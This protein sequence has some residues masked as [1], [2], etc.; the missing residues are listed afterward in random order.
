MVT[1]SPV[2]WK[3]SVENGILN[4]A[5]HPSSVCVVTTS[6]YEFQSQFIGMPL[7]NSASF[8]IVRPAAPPTD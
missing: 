5:N 3:P 7:V 4:S 1:S 2:T 8:D 6:Q